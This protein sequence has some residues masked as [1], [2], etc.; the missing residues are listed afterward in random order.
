V[1]HALL[2]ELGGPGRNGVAAMRAALAGRPPG[3]VATASGLEARFAR[4]LAEAGEAPLQRQVDLGGHAWIGRVDFVDRR[5]GIVVEVDSDVHHTSPLDRAHDRRRD[6]RLR[7]AG[8][9]AVVRVTEDEI[10]RRP[11]EAV[12]RVRDA[13][14]R[15][16]MA[17]VSGT[18]PAGPVSDTSA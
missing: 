5:L 14:R 8:W 12:A 17:L 6:D 11:A 4:L 9:S 18:G 2:A 10:W 16:T 7:A 13:R 3:Y 1:L 15:A